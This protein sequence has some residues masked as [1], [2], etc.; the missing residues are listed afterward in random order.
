MVWAQDVFVSV[1]KTGPVPQHVAFV[2]DG[3]RRFARRR[4]LEVREGHS[5]GFESLAH[6]CRSYLS[7]PALRTGY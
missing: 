4:K 2:M 7:V 6:V 5:A 1:L 3:N